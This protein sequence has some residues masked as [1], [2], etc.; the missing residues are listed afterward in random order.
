VVLASAE[1]G[2]EKLTMTAKKGAPCGQVQENFSTLQAIYLC[3][4]F[5]GTGV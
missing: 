2:G 5:F 4:F 3:T 1:N